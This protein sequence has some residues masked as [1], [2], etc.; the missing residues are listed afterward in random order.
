[1]TDGKWKQALPSLISSR[2]PAEINHIITNFYFKKEE[3][4]EKIRKIFKNPTEICRYLP[5]S[6]GKQSS[7]AFI[8]TTIRHVQAL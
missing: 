3:K 4:K 7:I 6:L 5:K 8:T 1:M 2:H